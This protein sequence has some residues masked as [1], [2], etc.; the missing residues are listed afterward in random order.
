[1]HATHRNAWALA[2]AEE[3]RLRS[4]IIKYRSSVAH[5]L[6]TGGVPP[7]DV[8]D[9][10][11]RTFMIAA[12]RLA[13]VRPGAESGFLY[14][15]ASRMAARSRRTRR[16]RREILTGDLPDVP[17]R[18]EQPAPPDSLVQHR[19]LWTYLAGILD[20]MR[21]SLRA[22]FV[23]CDLEGMPRHEI[24]TLLKLPDG[25]VASRLRVARRHV[26]RLVADEFAVVREPSRQSI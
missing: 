23:L 18:G 26:R 8:D 25:T 15:V 1:M 19:E 11:Q 14:R 21:A 24:A 2:A 12:R 4:M 3:A 16:R 13:D 9:E 5:T 10:V 7:S 22:V 20:R 6:L 17:S